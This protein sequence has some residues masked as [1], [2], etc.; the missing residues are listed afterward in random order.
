MS[1]TGGW[2]EGEGKGG[3]E[4]R[5][6]DLMMAGDDS[7]TEQQHRSRRE[8]EGERKEERRDVAVTWRRRLSLK[9]LLFLW[10]GTCPVYLCCHRNMLDVSLV[11]HMWL[12]KYS[13]L[14]KHILN[15]KLKL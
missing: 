14:F 12:R 8:R 5:D 10:H 3:R 7:R 9:L 1:I 11:V 15:E 4:G 13:F 2:R 6:R